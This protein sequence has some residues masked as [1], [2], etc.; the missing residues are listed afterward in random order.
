MY[1]QAV[2]IYLRDKQEPFILYIEKHYFDD[3]VTQ[4]KEL[5][6]NNHRI[7]NQSILVSASKAFEAILPSTECRY[8]EDIS[9]H[10]LPYSVS[11]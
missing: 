7:N 4:Y 2:E 6:I 1:V 11:V 9:M 5:G 10:C 8:E 3:L